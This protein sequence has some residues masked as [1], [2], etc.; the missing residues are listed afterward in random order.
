MTRTLNYERDEIIG[1]V[2][3]TVE[4]FAYTD[5]K[6]HS[7]MCKRVL[8]PID[9]MLKRSTIT[10]QQHAA[11]QRYRKDFDKAYTEALAQVNADKIIVDTKRT[12]WTPT[13]L[14]AWMRLNEL[15]TRLKGREGHVLRHCAGIGWPIQSWAEAH[16]VSVDVTRQTLITA[17]D[18]AARY[19]GV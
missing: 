18:K 19:Y 10:Y 6:G 9:H 11:G 4:G 1:G 3:R 12:D 8:D 16:E 17:L 7:Y 5:D 15:E 2:E 13:D 14:S